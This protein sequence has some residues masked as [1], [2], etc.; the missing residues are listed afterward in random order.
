MTEKMHF[1]RYVFNQHNM[2]ENILSK[3]MF[4]TIYIFIYMC[5]WRCSW[6]VWLWL[7]AEIMG[8]EMR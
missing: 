5:V 1:M 7:W 8:E 6:A 2:E 3:N 4:G